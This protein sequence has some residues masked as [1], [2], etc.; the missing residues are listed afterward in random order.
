MS[1]KS[2]SL[3]PTQSS[4]GLPG[5]L[6]SVPLFAA[7]DDAAVEELCG[8]LRLE[9]LEQGT[10]LFHVGDAGDAMYFIE[11]GGVRICVTDADGREVTLAELGA[12]DFF[13]EMAMLDGHGRSAD[14]VVTE[15]ARLAVLTRENFLSFVSSD[16]RVVLEMLAAITHRLR[17]TD[18]L[19][20]HRVSRNANEED[21]ANITIADRAAD[22]I[23]QFGGSWKFIGV[24]VLFFFIWIAINSWMLQSKTFDPFPYVLLNLALGMLTGLQAPIILMSQNREARKDRLRADLDYQVNLKNEMLLGEILRRL[25]TRHLPSPGDRRGEEH[26][27]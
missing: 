16:A 7:L 9:E 3:A 14:A 10:Q 23:A 27:R 25:E 4:D 12:G 5:R 24:N 15:D 11:G 18:E 26:F 20:R 17:R 1:T 21:A 19:L 13:G 22:T 6:R 8:L 2:P